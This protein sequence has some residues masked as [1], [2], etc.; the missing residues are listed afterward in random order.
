MVIYEPGDERPRHRQLALAVAAGAGVLAASAAAWWWGWR[1][2][3]EDLSFLIIAGGIAHSASESVQRKRVRKGNLVWRSALVLPGGV[4]AGYVAPWAWQAIAMECAASA[5]LLLG[6]LVPAAAWF[7]SDGWRGIVGAAGTA[8]GGWVALERARCVF[9]RVRHPVHTALTADGVVLKDTTVPWNLVKYGK[10]GK[11][12]VSLYRSG[13][14]KVL[15]G[16]PQCQVP[17]DRL[18]QVIEHFRAAPHRRSALEG[19]GALSGF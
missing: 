2:G 6:V 15:A 7:A 14:G 16:G 12:G 1:H 5:A 10:P 18:N 13:A 9:R 4:R 3:E 17:D 19:P 8:L 11:D